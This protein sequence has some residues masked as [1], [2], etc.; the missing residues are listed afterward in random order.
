[1]SLFTHILDHLPDDIQEQARKI[2][3]RIP[4][5]LQ[6]TEDTID[7]SFDFRPMSVYYRLTCSR[8]QGF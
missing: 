5:G 7:G 2:A 4:V 8:P 6:H 3:E 1:M